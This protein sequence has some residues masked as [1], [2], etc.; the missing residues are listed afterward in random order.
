[1]VHSWIL[2]SI[3]SLILYGLWGFWGAKASLLTDAKSV[4]FISCVGTMI[5][6]LAIIPLLS[7]INFTPASAL[8]SLLT[9]L[10]TGLGSLMFIYALQRGPTIPIVMITALYPLITIFLSL[11]FLGQSMN[12]KQIIGVVFACLAIICFTRG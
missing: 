12:A 4:F 8:F 1:M 5:A 11:L 3:I 10:A 2:P 7:K 6:G 9:G